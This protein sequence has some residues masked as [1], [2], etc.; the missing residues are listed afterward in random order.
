VD[1]GHTPPQGGGQEVP[2]VEHAADSTKTYPWCKSLI[3]VAE[4][5]V[6][7]RARDRLQ[8]YCRACQ[9]AY[10]KSYYDKSPAAHIEKQRQRHVRLWAQNRPLLDEYLR[11][12]PCVDG[13]ET[14][15]LVL[16]FD[17]RDPATKRMNVAEMLYDYAWP[18]IAA[19]SEKCDVRCA[20]CHRRRTARQLGWSTCPP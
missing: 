11:E 9:R 1:G 15:A 8:P 6:R 5:N 18:L 2:L 14:D 4:F 10:Y 13:G 3:A 16:D 20:N 12:H 7:Q 17:H 19:E